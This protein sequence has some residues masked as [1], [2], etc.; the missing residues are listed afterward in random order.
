M[1][2]HLICW[3]GKIEGCSPVRSRLGPHLAAMKL[4]DPLHRGQPDAETSE[5]LSTRETLERS[6]EFF[7]IRRIK[8]RPVCESASKIDPLSAPSPDPPQ[9]LT[10]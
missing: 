1:S 9:P 4:D 8:T 7:R 10:H 6:K 2:D 3:K 5:F